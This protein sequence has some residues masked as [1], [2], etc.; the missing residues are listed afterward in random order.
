MKK[1]NIHEQWGNL[2]YVRIEGEDPPPVLCQYSFK[3]I[4][5]YAD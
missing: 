3:D 5:V 2:Q 4:L 1:K